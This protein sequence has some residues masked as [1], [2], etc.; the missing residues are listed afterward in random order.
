[1]L[2]L[3]LRRWAALVTLSALQQTICTAAVTVVAPAA[4]APAVAV[5]A[6]QSIKFAR[7]LGLRLTDNGTGSGSALRAMPQGR[8]RTA[9]ARWVADEGP[10]CEQLEGIRGCAPRF[11]SKICK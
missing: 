2:S 6:V 4:A 9:A 3:L 1:M 8:N 5:A 7:V 10:G 11:T